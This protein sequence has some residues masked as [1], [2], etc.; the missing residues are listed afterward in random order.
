MFFFPGGDTDE[1]NWEMVVVVDRQSCIR[2]PCETAEGLAG[3]EQLSI[4][5]SYQM[6][7]DSE[8]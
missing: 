4:Y 1:S 2:S 6:R 8:R 3:R 7:R 5:D